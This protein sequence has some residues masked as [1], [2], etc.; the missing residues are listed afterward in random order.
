MWIY[1]KYFRTLQKSDAVDI[2][3]LP[4]EAL[5]IINKYSYCINKPNIVCSHNKIPEERKRE[6]EANDFA[7]KLLMPEYKFVKIF[8]KYKGN[9]KKIA[10]IFGV[11]IRAC[12]VRAFNLGLID[13]L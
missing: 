1:N 4:D 2:K 8:E 9:T 12:E 11:S 3:A 7:L 5:E 6:Y 13:S 10:D